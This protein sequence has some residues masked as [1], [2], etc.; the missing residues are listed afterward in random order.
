MAV[1]LATGTALIIAVGLER[2]SSTHK[3]RWHTHSAI[4]RRVDVQVEAVLRLLAAMGMRLAGKPV[5]RSAQ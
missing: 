1:Y 5:L 4:C 3:F 2:A